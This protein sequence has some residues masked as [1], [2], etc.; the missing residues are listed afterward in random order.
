MNMS[1]QNNIWIIKEQHAS[2]EFKQEGVCT[3]HNSNIKVDVHSQETKNIYT[4]ERF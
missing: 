1:Q 4:W 2:I 3:S